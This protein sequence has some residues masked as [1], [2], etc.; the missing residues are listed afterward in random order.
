MGNGC[1][2]GFVAD[3]CSQCCDDREL[4]N[5][6]AQLARVT[7]ER[8]RVISDAI[9]AT[10]HH[11]I[12]AERAE[13]EATRL[14]SEIRELKTVALGAC[15]EILAIPEIP[16]A[17]ARQLGQLREAR[18]MLAESLNSEGTDPGPGAAKRDRG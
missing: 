14:R 13:A 2:H 9:A 15:D 12:R 7:A 4:A 5:L 16:A 3:T 18:D 10:T 1:K 11:D 8:D 6:R 17:L